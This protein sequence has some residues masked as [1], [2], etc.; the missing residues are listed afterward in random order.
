ML[1]KTAIHRIT[2]VLLLAFL[3]PVIFAFWYI[4]I[5]GVMLGLTWLF[6]MAGWLILRGTKE[7]AV[8]AEAS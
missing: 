1:S 5:I 8:A 7:A 3:A 4:G 2:G 6:L